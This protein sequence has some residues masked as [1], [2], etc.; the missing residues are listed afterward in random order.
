MHHLPDASIDLIVAGPPYANRFDYEHSAKSGD[1]VS[2]S[3]NQSSIQDI[4]MQFCANLHDWFSECYRVLKDGRYCAVNI[5]TIHYKGQTLPLPFWAVDCLEKVGF[6]FVV[7]I[8]WKKT[9]GSRRH[10]RSF[11]A[12]PI[13]GRFLPNIQT[14]YVLIFNKNSTQSFY[15]LGISPNAIPKIPLSEIVRREWANNVWHLPIGNPDPLHPCPFPIELPWR[16]IQ[17]YSLPEDTVLDPFMG[18]ATTARA[19]Q[20]LNRYFIG[21]E[22]H[23]AFIDRGYELLAQPP[24]KIRESISILQRYSKPNTPSK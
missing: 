3:D 7:D 9:N 5:G 19:A 23:K 24:P 8:I 13:P 16:L 10:S 11:F 14:E 4:K 2:F 12:N 18:I 21:Y 15:P 6:T 20:M 22:R 1:R 17:L